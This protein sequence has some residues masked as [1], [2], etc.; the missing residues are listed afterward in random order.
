MSSLRAGVIAVLLLAPGAAASAQVLQP[1]PRTTGGLFGGD[2][3]VDPNR[4]RQE[5]TLTLDALAGYGDVLLN[6]GLSE[7]TSPDG[8]SENSYSGLATATGRYW[9]GR[10]ARHIE[11]TGSAQV[12]SYSTALSGPLIGGHGG[13]SATTSLGSRTSV[14]ADFRAEYRPTYVLGSFG[15]VSDGVSAGVATDPTGGATEIRTLSRGSHAGLRREWT[16]RQ[17]SAVEYSLGYFEFSGGAEANSTM[18]GQSLTHAWQF[19]RTSGIRVAYRRETWQSVHTV[20]PTDSL[21]HNA[22]FGLDY[23]K[24]LSRTRQLAF[25]FGAGVMRGEVTNGETYLAP[26][27]HG[28]AQFDF[29]R[30]WNIGAG[31][32]R[33]ATVLEGITRSSFLTSS[34]GLT[35]GGRV[36]D[37]VTLAVSGQFSRGTAAAGAAGS[38]ETINGTVQCDY[39]LARWGSVLMNYSS[40]GHTLRGVTG[41]PEGLPSRF[42][43]QSVRV[44]I[45][46]WLPLYGSFERERG[47]TTP[48]S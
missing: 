44:G 12:V 10:A 26:S 41:I 14:D 25:A 1:P 48:R 3:P 6:E 15:D 21:T 22:D 16:T 47:R 36:H 32:Q 5:L 40:Y 43:R 8:G 45:T 38:F 19:S 4:S 20:G 7:L 11:A 18:H 42:Q 17:H 28:S 13:V 30:T 27:A 35:L 33:H 31:V 2:R 23:R 46:V 39:A 9:L 34:V 24:R 29:A 37:R